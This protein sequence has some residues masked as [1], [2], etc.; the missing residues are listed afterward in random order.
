MVEGFTPGNVIHQQGSGSSP[1]VGTGDRAEGF[2]ASRIPDL[3]FDLL[4][5]NG[6]HAGPKLHTYCEVV[7]RLKPLVCKLQEET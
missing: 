6:D 7:N 4:S 2:L 3:Q 1:V 5:I